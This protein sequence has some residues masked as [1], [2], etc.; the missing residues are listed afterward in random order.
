M[1]TYLQL[2]RRATGR[3]TKTD[4][5]G[6]KRVPEPKPPPGLARCFLLSPRG[7]GRTGAR[8]RGEARYIRGPGHGAGRVEA[9]RV[10]GCSERPRLPGPAPC[11]AAPAAPPG[12]ENQSGR[13]AAR[14]PAP[15]DSGRGGVAAEPVDG[16]RDAGRHTGPALLRHMRIRACGGPARAAG[17]RRTLGPSARGTCPS[18]VPRVGFPRRVARRIRRGRGGVGRDQPPRHAHRRQH[19]A[20]PPP[21]KVA[22]VAFARISAGPDGIG[23]AD[24]YFDTSRCHTGGAGR[25]HPGVAEGAFRVGPE[26]LAQAGPHDVPGGGDRSRRRDEIARRGAA[27]KGEAVSLSTEGTARSFFSASAASGA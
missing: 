24:G 4:G 16:S 13:G 25:P 11:Q 23:R 5:P 2:A 17:A 14:G 19:G 8:R 12:S 6:E 7:G 1:K 3:I 27:G 22:A 18:H 26:P 21:R 15:A 10:R 20:L 9:G